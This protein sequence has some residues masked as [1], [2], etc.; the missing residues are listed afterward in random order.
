MEMIILRN[1][2]KKHLNEDEVIKWMKIPEPLK[3][4]SNYGHKIIPFARKSI[5]RSHLS[6]IGLVWNE[7]YSVTT[8]ETITTMVFGLSFNIV[9]SH[10]MFY[11][12]GYVK[13]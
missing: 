4:L 11:E 7:E 10:E 12:P 13:I 9:P 1:E 8:A 6:G 3:N 2:D 5:D